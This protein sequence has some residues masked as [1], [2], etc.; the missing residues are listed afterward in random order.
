MHV[1]ENVQS[2]VH[3]RDV[4]SHLIQQINQFASTPSFIPPKRPSVWNGLT[5]EQDIRRRRWPQARQWRSLIRGIESVVP[6]SLLTGSAPMTLVDEQ[7]YHWQWATIAALQQDSDNSIHSAMD[8]ASSLTIAIIERL[9]PNPVRGLTTPTASCS[10]WGTRNW[11]LIPNFG[12][13][14]WVGGGGSHIRLCAI[15]NELDI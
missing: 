5:M 6:S 1:M 3:I 11:T 4:S 7:W 9:R 12:I 15:S 10:D 8:N 13:S 2:Q 14:F